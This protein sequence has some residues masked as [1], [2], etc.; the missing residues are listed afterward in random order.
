MMTKFCQHFLFAP[1]LLTYVPWCSIH[2]KE[3]ELKS[4]ILMRITTKSYHSISIHSFSF[5]S[6]I[7]QHHHIIH[8]YV[9]MTWQPLNFN[10][11]SNVPSLYTTCIR[12]L[13]LFYCPHKIQLLSCACGLKC[14]IGSG[15]DVE[16]KRMVW[17]ANYWKNVSAVH[18][19]S[20]QLAVSSAN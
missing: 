4:H 19:P 17:H 16:S 5:C 18:H 8:M 14:K 15:W 3:K 9:K 12:F 6:S 7:S 20:D 2:N 13:F 11:N 1:T 10:S